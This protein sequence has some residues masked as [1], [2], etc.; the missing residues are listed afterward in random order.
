V[1]K[2]DEEVKK[3]VTMMKAVFRKLFKSSARDRV[4]V[5]ANNNVNHN[6]PEGGNSNNNVKSANGSPSRRIKW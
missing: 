5:T 2:E 3:F 6:E 1:K 4:G